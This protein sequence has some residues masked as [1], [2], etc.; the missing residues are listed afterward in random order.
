MD[1][2]RKI[3][4]V[5]WIDKDESPVS[6]AGTAASLEASD[7]GETGHEPDILALAERAERHRAG[8]TNKHR[9]GAT[10]K[11]RAGATNEHR[12]GAATKHRAGANIKH[13]MKGANARLE[14]KW[15]RGENVCLYV[16]M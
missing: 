14:P 7:V 15:L 16:C 5:V 2:L 4:C 1:N 10:N 3:F 13:R 6:G 9:A 11:H 12:A 8:A